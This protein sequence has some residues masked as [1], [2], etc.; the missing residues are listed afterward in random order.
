LKSENIA[1]RRQHYYRQ[2]SMEMYVRQFLIAYI[3]YLDDYKS[4]VQLVYG[5]V[6][7]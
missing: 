2:I 3:E 7:T 4:T 6:N 5:T 1:D